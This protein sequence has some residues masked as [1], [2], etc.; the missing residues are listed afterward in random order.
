M[1]LTPGEVLGELLPLAL[2]EEA[3]LLRVELEGVLLVAPL[4]LLQTADLLPDGLE[5]REHPP[6]ASAR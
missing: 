5:V 4:E 2:E 6:R 3:L 1:S